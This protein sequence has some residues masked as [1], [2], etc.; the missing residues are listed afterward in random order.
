MDETQTIRAGSGRAEP[1]VQLD[2]MSVAEI[3]RR[4]NDLDRAVPVAIGAALPAINAA[5]Q[6]AEVGF[7]SG[8]RLIYV[9]AGTSGRLAVLDA[10][11]CPPTFH[12]DPSRVV[13]LLAGGPRALVDA[14]EGAEDDAE[15]GAA[16]L[17]E[18]APGP[19]DTVVGIAAS[20][21]T[22]YVRG[23]LLAAGQAGAV[24]VSLSCVSPAEL[25][26]LADHPIEVAVGPEIL[27]GSTRLKAGTAQKQVLN[28]F[29]TALMARSGRTYGNLMVKVAAT[30]D[31]LRARALGLVQTIAQ[32]DEASA[33]AALVAADYDVSTATVMVVREED[34]TQARA[35]LTAARGRLGD[36][37]GIASSAHPA[38]GEP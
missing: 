16:A 8:G 21:R 30:N 26:P 22:P 17:R 28:M 14:V 1:P 37:I 31:K 20:G 33:R 18:L 25:S 32:V 24:T 2:E 34:A 19:L 23:A 29:S 15:A 27:S 10:A 13:G 4:M 36:A 38:L 11:E 35:R 12:T 6:A 9:G 7:S 5:I 3:T